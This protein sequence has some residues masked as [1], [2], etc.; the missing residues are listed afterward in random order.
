MPKL[1]LVLSNRSSC[2]A[3]NPESQRP[4][5]HPQERDNNHHA[6]NTQGAQDLPS[7]ASADWCR[8]QSKLCQLGSSD[9]GMA[10]LYPRPLFQALA[11]L[12]SL[13]PR[14]PGASCKCG[15]IFSKSVEVSGAIQAES[16]F[17]AFCVCHVRPCYFDFCRQLLA[18]GGS[19]A[20]C[21]CCFEASNH[22]SATIAGSEPWK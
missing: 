14:L 19:E 2:L 9:V 18:E 13:C 7:G 1:N 20:D 10:N 17:D 6:G 12:S 5:E 8:A 21:L 16:Q 22:I 4:S 3:A 11:T 15:G